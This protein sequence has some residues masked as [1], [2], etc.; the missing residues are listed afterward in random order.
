[1]L[2]AYFALMNTII[3]IY[4]LCFVSIKDSLRV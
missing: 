4:R 2:S 3:E 1:M